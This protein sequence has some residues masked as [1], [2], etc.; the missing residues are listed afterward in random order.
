MAI[1]PSD[2]QAEKANQP[3]A[4]IELSPMG[5]A[6]KQLRLIDRDSGA[7]TAIDE[8][9]TKPQG[10]D[11]LQAALESAAEESIRNLGPRLLDAIMV[12]SVGNPVAA[13]VASVAKALIQAVF[14]TTSTLEKKLDAQL[15]EP[16]ATAVTTLSDVLSVHAITEAELTECERLLT[17]VADNLA[18]AYTYAQKT[19]PACCKDVRAYQVLVSALRS[20]GRP[21]LELYSQDLLDEAKSAREE[22]AKLLH[23]AQAIRSGDFETV[24]SLRHHWNSVND[25]SS[26]HGLASVVGFKEMLAQR[27]SFLNSR[28]EQLDRRADAYERFCIFVEQVASRRTEVLG[29]P[30]SD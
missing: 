17:N 24:E 18:K 28:A 5:F 12:A 11:I 26:P 10:M 25:M 16:M 20:G 14:H 23:E 27:A 13:V 4:M 2:S 29:A 1:D 6:V 21:F 22:S 8:P 3:N 9:M 7:T 30:V 15:T 19:D